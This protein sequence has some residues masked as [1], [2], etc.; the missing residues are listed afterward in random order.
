MFVSRAATRPFHEAVA[1]RALQIDSPAE[2]GPEVVSF[3]N[4]GIHDGDVRLDA[5]Q[6]AALAF[7]APLSISIREGTRT[8]TAPFV[9]L[10]LAVDGDAINEH[11]AAT[12]LARVR[13]L[14]EAP[15]AL[16]AA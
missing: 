7:G 11:A 6:R 12:L 9:T 4:L 3:S 13:E 10:T 8:V 2:P 16:L 5:G 15:Y 14:L 1:D